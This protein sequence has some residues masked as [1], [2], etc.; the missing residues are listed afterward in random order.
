MPSER[1]LF[2]CLRP[3][4]H[5]HTVHTAQQVT[6]RPDL[7]AGHRRDWQAGGSEVEDVQRAVSLFLVM[8][9]LPAGLILLL[10]GFPSGVRLDCSHLFF[11]RLF[12]MQEAIAGRPLFLAG[13]GC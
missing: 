6:L 11:I 8:Q 1:Q 2:L 10:S 5:P 7:K 13:Q 3:R 9:I 12:V 4:C